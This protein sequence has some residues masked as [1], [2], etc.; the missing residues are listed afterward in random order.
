MLARDCNV[1][2]RDSRGYTPLH[3]TVKSRNLELMFTL[4]GYGSNINAISYAS[5]CHDRFQIKPST[6]LY[7]AAKFNWVEAVTLLIQHG[8]GSLET[9]QYFIKNN[10]NQ[11]DLC[12]TIQKA[13]NDLD[14]IEI[15]YKAGTP[16]DH[17]G[18]SGWSALGYAARNGLD[19]FV[20]KLVKL[21]ADLD[22]INGDLTALGNAASRDYTNIV[23]ILL[24]AGAQTD[25][26]GH[27]MST[28]QQLAISQG[29]GEIAD[30]IARYA[31]AGSTRKLIDTI[32]T[33]V[34]DQETAMVEG[35]LKV[36]WDPTAA[37]MR[38][39]VE[40]VERLI[41]KGCSL[42]IGKNWKC[43]PLYLAINWQHWA[44]ARKLIEAGAELNISNENENTNNDMPFM[45]VVIQD[46]TAFIEM[47]IRH[48]A[49]VNILSMQRCMKG[50]GYG[51]YGKV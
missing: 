51:G 29:Y 20:E 6:P 35:S 44:V 19:G 3:Y 43:S 18:L 49:D 14:M 4:I 48:G 26:T 38:G 39:N 45:E 28:P 32:S 33:C 47:M 23:Q 36:G 7:L 40:V 46:N 50:L 17:V 30:K 9:V 15:L 22:H 1:N 24:A 31:D 21:G 5:K 11:L 27:H 8:A 41:E 2:I 13:G 12:G 25:L 34:V 16:I 42:R 37:A 10:V